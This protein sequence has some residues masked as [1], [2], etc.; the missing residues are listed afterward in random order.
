M[1]KVERIESLRLRR[2][3]KDIVKATVS[4]EV[5][6]TLGHHLVEM[7][8]AALCEDYDHLTELANVIKEAITPAPNRGGGE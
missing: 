6:D 1:E 4:G 3:R 8:D 2:T 5:G 7:I